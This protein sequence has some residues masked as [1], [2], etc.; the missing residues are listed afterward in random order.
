M[1][2]EVELEFKPGSLQQVVAK[3]LSLP[4]GL[5]PSHH[6]LG[7]D[8]KWQ[9]INDPKGFADSL[10]ERSPGP[11]LTGRGCSYHFS[12]PIPKPIACRCELE[13]EG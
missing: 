10:E 2:I 7:E 9:L 3:L 1:S 13:V 6:S 8:E 4:P 11:F 5:R 12:L